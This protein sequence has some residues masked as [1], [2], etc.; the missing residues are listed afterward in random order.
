MFTWL[1]VGRAWRNRRFWRFRLDRFRF[2]EFEIEQASFVPGRS[3]SRLERQTPVRSRPKNTRPCCS[4]IAEQSRVRRRRSRQLDL[5][6]GWCRVITGRRL[7]GRRGEV[8][9]ALP[10]PSLRD[11]LMLNAIRDVRSKYAID[12]R[13]SF[14]NVTFQSRRSRPHRGIGCL[15]FVWSRP[16]MLAVV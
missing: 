9:R 8:Q 10:Q 2:T 15:R 7:F 5:G 13:C 1:V 4:N 14:G 6:Q 11:W 16:E 3:R 12:R